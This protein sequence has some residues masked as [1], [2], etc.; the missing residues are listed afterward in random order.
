MVRS[1]RGYYC[2]LSIRLREF[3]SRTHR[4]N[5]DL[6]V[7]LK[8][9]YNCILQTEKSNKCQHNTTLMPCFPFNIQQCGLLQP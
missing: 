9:V 4:Q 3:D 8:S 2:G 6:E 5:F 7:E 1:Y